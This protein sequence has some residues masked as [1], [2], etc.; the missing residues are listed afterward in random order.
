MVRRALISV[1]ER[2][3]LIDFSRGLV[4]A[5][6]ALFAS[7]GTAA[8]LS[9]NGVSVTP[10][11]TLTGFADLLG[12]R[13]KT[14][15]PAVHA[16]ILARTDQLDELAAAKL[17]PFDL[18]V[19]NL[20]AFD[21]AVLKGAPRE[22][23][24]EAI[25]IGGVALVRAA[26]KNHGRVGVLVGPDQ[27]PA[28]LQ[29]LEDTGALSEDTR[30]ALASEAFALTSG[31]DAAVH[32]YLSVGGAVP[33]HLR[34]A[35]EKVQDL[36]YGEN[37]YQGAAF[38]ADPRAT[39]TSLATSRQL[40]G[41]ALSYNNLLDLD[42]ALRIAVDFEET[43]AVV[44]KHANPSG[45]ALREDLTSAVR[46]AFE[47]DPI[48]AYG[49]VV[50]VNRPVTMAVAEELRPRFV[51]AILAP[52]YEPDALD[53]LR[54]KK[55]KLRI[56]DAGGPLVRS[57][58]PE[59]VR[60]AGGTLVQTSDR[61]PMDPA[62]WKVVTKATP[63]D[64]QRSDLAFATA[65]C[66]FAKSNAIVLAR[67]RTTVGIGAGQMSRVDACMLAGYKAKERAKG[68]SLASDAFFP[69]RDGLDEAA[70]VGVAAVVQPG[71]SIR[72]EEVVAAADEHGMAM[73]FTG[74]RLFRH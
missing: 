4:D 5:G 56:V 67:D 68:A 19:A 44:I 27:Y 50:G 72:D 65:I 1:T 52:G 28:V 41:Q 74:T 62:T 13:V 59:R 48:S 18:V 47:A 6:Y 9:E 58:D 30:R 25:D 61:P 37:P 24:L 60:I 43:C 54:R 11:S 40:H 29:E 32:T 39:G 7:D 10:L 23:V 34:I 21:A 26:A 53:L 22:E 64:G 69:F 36:R 3:G 57:S 51:E 63:T 73:V 70:K 20:Y 15:H 71:G 66:R 16:G 38:Y 8:F 45:V 31:Y 35:Q 2:D 12:G 14:L 17:E 49:G 46:E 33:D 55:K 42:A